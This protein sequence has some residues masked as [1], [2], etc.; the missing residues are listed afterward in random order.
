MKPLDHAIRQNIHQEVNWFWHLGESKPHHSEIA[1]VSF[2]LDALIALLNPDPELTARYKPK[3]PTTGEV[4]QEKRKRGRPP[5]PRSYLS[6]D[7]LETLAVLHAKQEQ[8][9]GTTIGEIVGSLYDLQR[10]VDATPAPK[11]KRGNKSLDLW[12]VRAIELIVDQWKR[13][14]SGS[15]GIE[16][17]ENT[18]PKSAFAKWVATESNLVDPVAFPKPARNDRDAREKITNSNIKTVLVELRKRQFPSPDPNWS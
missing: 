11:G 13:Q 12:K 10:Y 4:I 1:M 15:M 7:S 9:G 2:H 5:D 14:G 17:D 16:F 3:D 8:I 18:N 6:E